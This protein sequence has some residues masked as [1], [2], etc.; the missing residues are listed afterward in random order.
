MAHDSAGDFLAGFIIGAV[1]GAAAALLLAPQSGQETRT[2]IRETGLELRDRAEEL[3]LEARREADRLA[4]EAAKRARDVEQRGRIV[5]EE[6]KHKVQEVV[7]K[8]RPKKAA[9][10]VPEA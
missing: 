4:E 6:Q 9:P 8:A 5:L 7:Q 3:S 1:V 10:A 2:R